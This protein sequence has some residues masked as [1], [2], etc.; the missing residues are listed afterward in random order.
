MKKS[1]TCIVCPVSCQLV[2]EEVEG[3]LTISNYQCKRGLKFGEDEY[4]QPKR[5]LT[6]TVRITGGDVKRLPVISVDELAKDQ[7]IDIAKMLYKV[8]VKSPVYRGDIIIK[9]IA[10]T[11]VDIMATRTILKKEEIRHGAN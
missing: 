9:N 10:S 1:F 5:I 7:L 6:T 2:V 3:R 11:G 4:R 8:S